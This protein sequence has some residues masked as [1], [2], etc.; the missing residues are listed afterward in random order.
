MLKKNPC[1]LEMT[2]IYDI[3]KN[4]R[5]IFFFSDMSHLIPS[6]DQTFHDQKEQFNIFSREKTNQ[7]IQA[8]ALLDIY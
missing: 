4:T 7:N 3:M 2:A 8:I 1:A 5:W 6:L